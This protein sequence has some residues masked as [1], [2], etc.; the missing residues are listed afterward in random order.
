MHDVFCFWSTC[1]YKYNDLKEMIATNFTVQDSSC[2]FFSRI[3]PKVMTHIGSRKAVSFSDCCQIYL[4]SLDCSLFIRLTNCFKKFPLPKKEK[5]YVHFFETY[6]KFKHSSSIR[7]ALWIFSSTNT[8]YVLVVK[9]CN[10]RSFF[11]VYKEKIFTKNLVHV[12]TK[13]T[14]LTKKLHTIYSSPIKC[15]KLLGV[16]LSA[17]QVFVQV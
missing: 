9:W 13:N 16:K 14:N 5:I 17:V 15:P 1:S 10:S 12:L 7:I 3:L 4:Y 2:F 6:L 11:E 8:Y